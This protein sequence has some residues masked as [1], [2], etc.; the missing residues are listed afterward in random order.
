MSDHGLDVAPATAREATRRSFLGRLLGGTLVMGA[1]GVV[2]SVI[3]YLFPPAT[4][5]TSLG[6]QR[7]RVG[8]DDELAVGAGKLVL[9]NEEPVW[10]VKLQQG[11][12][13]LAATC[14]H[15][16]CL[17]KWEGARRVFSCPCHE[18]LFDE[19][20][21]VVSGLPRRPLAHVRVGIVGGDVYVSSAG[22]RPA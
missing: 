3:A 6:P 14:T 12:V 8:R 10:V 21:N 5:R 15:K 11:F 7:V 19:R 4:V 1:A 18:G 16:G 17:V 20:G 22:G 13:A 2:A 9:V